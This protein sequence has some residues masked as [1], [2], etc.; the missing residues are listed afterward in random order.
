MAEDLILLEK[1]EWLEKFKAQVYKDFELAGA[2]QHLPDM[3]TN[4]LEALRQSFYQSVLKL[5]TGNALKNLVYR[6]DLTEKQ[7]GTSAQQQPE[8]PLQL[9]LAELMIKRIL[10]KIVLKEL[11][12]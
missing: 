7:I 5:E 10:Q 8:K 4:T 9:V 12:K 1:P 6:I 2:L 11:Y 3:G